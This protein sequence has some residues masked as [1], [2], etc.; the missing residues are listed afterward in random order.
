MQPFIFV[1]TAV[2]AATVTAQGCHFWVREKSTG[3]NVLQKCLQKNEGTTALI[4]GAS[5]Y[6]QADSNC[7]VTVSNTGYNTAPVRF[8]AFY[9]GPC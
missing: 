8:D 1:L 4:N 2:F 7:R 6:L 3:N 9:D 5:V